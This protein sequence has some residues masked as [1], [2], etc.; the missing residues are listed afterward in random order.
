[1]HN[2]GVLS[3]GRFQGR[4]TVVNFAMKFHDINFCSRKLEIPESA[5]A[6]AQEK[7]FELQGYAFEARWESTRSPRV[8]RVGAIQNRIVVPTT[9][10]IVEQVRIRPKL[11]SWK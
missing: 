3:F 2:F 11:N 7:D 1:M 5:Q 8:I 9:A 6:L 10:S 4:H